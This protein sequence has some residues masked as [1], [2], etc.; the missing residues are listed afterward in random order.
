V[1]CGFFNA[2]N[3]VEMAHIARLNP[4]GSID[5]SFHL[6][7]MTLERFSRERFKKK[8]RVPVA[9]VAEKA[10]ASAAANPTASASSQSVESTVLITSMES[11]NGRMTIGF[12]GKARQQ[13]ILQAKDSFDAA[14]WTN[15]VTN[16]TSAGALGTFTDAASS[17]HSTRFYR[18]AVP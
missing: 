1:I 3:G 17:E 8:F 7:F 5:P 9:R 15:L 6:P 18:I 14:V 12:I 10:A 4:D 2:V 11:V 13:Y 16:R